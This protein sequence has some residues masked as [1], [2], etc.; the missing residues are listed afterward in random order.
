MTRVLLS[1]GYNRQGEDLNYHLEEEK[2]PIKALI[3]YKERMLEVQKHLED[4]MAYLEHDSTNFQ[5]EAYDDFI[6]ITTSDKLAAD[7][8][9]EELVIEL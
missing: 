9:T 8:L 3:A 5:I 6:Y 7:L 2:N 1:L 4:V